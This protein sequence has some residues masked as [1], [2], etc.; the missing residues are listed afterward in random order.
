MNVSDSQAEAYNNMLSSH[1]LSVTSVT[2]GRHTHGKVL[3]A[4]P[5]ADNNN[6]L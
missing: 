5:L 4:S 6:N 3:Q 2:L 1:V